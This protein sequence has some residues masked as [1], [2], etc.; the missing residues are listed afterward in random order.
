MLSDNNNNNKNKYI[1]NNLLLLEEDIAK[2]HEISNRAKKINQDIQKEARASSYYTYRK[3]LDSD[4][5][6]ENYL[7]DV[8]KEREKTQYNKLFKPKPSIFSKE[9]IKNIAL[10]IRSGSVWFVMFFVSLV[11]LY[12]IFDSYNKEDNTF[13]EITGSEYKTGYEGNLARGD[14]K[15]LDPKVNSDQKDKLFKLF[16]MKN[17]NQINTEQKEKIASNLG[18]LKITNSSKPLIEDLEVEP[19]RI[20]A[21]NVGSGK[22]QESYKEQVKREG[23]EKEVQ[24]IRDLVAANTSAE[25]VLNI[26]EEQ[27]MQVM[28]G[29]TEEETL[30]PTTK[31]L[32]SNTTPTTGGSVTVEQ[33]KTQSMFER[34]V[35]QVQVYSAQ[36]VSDAKRQWVNMQKVNPELFLDQRLHILEAYV[37]GKKYYRLRIGFVNSEDENKG[38][39]ATKSQAVSFCGLLRDEGIDCYPTLTEFTE[40]K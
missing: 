19:N 25:Q 8:Q 40:L 26:Q 18:S 32:P 29:N 24:S 11:A 22:D 28:V 38:Y 30:A 36:S 31:K 37:D 39:F 2:T 16:G 15:F 13:V 17:K 34:K 9:G 23:T 14:F 27:P 6:V 12:L 35:W 7:E 33:Q 4:R 10:D 5:V 3:F 20:V 21:S 1:D